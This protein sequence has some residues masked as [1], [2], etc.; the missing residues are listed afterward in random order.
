MDPDGYITVTEAARLVGRSTGRLRQAIL[1]ER[2]PAMKVGPIWLVRVIDVR[3]W[4][5]S[6][7]TGRPRKDRT[8]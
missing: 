1:A 8:T 6:R 5:A 7:R 2:L 3:A 4:A